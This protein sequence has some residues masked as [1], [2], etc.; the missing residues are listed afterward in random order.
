MN[1]CF[2][3]LFLCSLSQEVIFGN[4]IAFA[5]PC[6]AGTRLG[7]QSIA[8]DLQATRIQ[9]LP[10]AAGILLS[11][12]AHRVEVVTFVMKG[13]CVLLLFLLCYAIKTLL[14]MGRDNVSLSDG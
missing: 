2:I 1:E 9:I 11:A 12:R 5:L 4:K 6:L 3:I 14:S 7:Q 13:M 10:N 8:A